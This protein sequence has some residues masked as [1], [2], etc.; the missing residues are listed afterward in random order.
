M[1]IPDSM[2]KFA[3]NK[4]F[5]YLYFAIHIKHN[6]VLPLNLTCLDKSTNITW[7]KQPF[8]QTTKKNGCFVLFAK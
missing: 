1:S 3:T 5:D 7:M 4:L 2:A 6:N 8:Q